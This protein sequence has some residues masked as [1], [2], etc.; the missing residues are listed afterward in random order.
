[1]AESHNVQTES[2]RH[3]LRK[4]SRNWKKD[5]RIIAVHQKFLITS[6]TDIP[7]LSQYT[8]GLA[9]GRA[10]AACDI[11]G[12]AYDEEGMAEVCIA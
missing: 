5:A 10:R 7:F 4:L 12:A 3:N 6:M 9:A 8:L 1:M 2:D 11:W